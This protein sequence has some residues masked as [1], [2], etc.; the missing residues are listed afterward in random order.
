MS[1]KDNLGRLGSEDPSTDILGQAG[2]IH[3]YKIIFA[4]RRG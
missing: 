4:M 1:I 2:M 3:T